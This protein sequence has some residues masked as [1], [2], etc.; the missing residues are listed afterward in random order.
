M[1]DCSSLSKGSALQ[2]NLDFETEKDMIDKFRVGLA[3]QPVSG[4]PHVQSVSCSGCM[5]VLQESYYLL[6]GRYKST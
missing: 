6:I 4:L 2:V 5:H 1:L 3:L